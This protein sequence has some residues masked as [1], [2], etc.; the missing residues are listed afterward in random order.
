LEG[1][2]HNFGAGLVRLI[3]AGGADFAMRP[4]GNI[5]DW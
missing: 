2:G 5:W 1:S 3:M 4:S